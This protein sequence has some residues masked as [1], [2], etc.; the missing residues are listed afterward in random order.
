[1][2]FAIMDKNKLFI[3][4]HDEQGTGWALGRIGTLKDWREQA[5]DWADGDD[6]EGTVEEL[7]GT[8]DSDL[9]DVINEIWSICIKPIN[10][11][12]HEEFDN[13]KNIMHTMQ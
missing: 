6:A 3:N 8:K 5:I 2:E 13:L 10:E 4:T 11:L 1:M 12:T 7:K 9:I